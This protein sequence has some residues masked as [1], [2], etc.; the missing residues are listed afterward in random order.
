MLVAKSGDRPGIIVGIYPADPDP[1]GE[2]AR[3]RAAAPSPRPSRRV[4]SMCLECSER[5]PGQERTGT[6]A[7]DVEDYLLVVD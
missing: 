5:L 2:S 7:N 1:A 4:R 6:P 3:G